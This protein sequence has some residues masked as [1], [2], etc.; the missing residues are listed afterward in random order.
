LLCLEALAFVCQCL[1]PQGQRWA[2]TVA[3]QSLERFAV[4]I[5]NEEA[6]MQREAIAEPPGPGAAC[7]PA[8]PAQTQE[9]GRAKAA[10][11]PAQ[12]DPPR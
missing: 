5:S 7:L 8:I 1:A 12:E 4:H 11:P 9:V 3:G 2:D 10:T 6:A